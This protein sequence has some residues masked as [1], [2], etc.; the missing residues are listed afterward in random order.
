LTTSKP[1]TTCAILKDIVAKLLTHGL[2][3]EFHVDED[4]FEN[5][6]IRG[7]VTGGTGCQELI[8]PGSV[9]YYYVK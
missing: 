2:S 8:A 1:G 9:A 4:R 7:V 3:S 5:L 6:S